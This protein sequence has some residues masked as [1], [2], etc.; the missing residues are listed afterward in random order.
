M[1]DLVVKIK[2]RKD[3]QTQKNSTNF[4]EERAEQPEEKGE[5]R[6]G[7]KEEE[8]R[9]E[10]KRR[11]WETAQKLNFELVTS[12][13]RSHPQEMRGGGKATEVMIRG[14]ILRRFA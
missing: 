11:R 3:K 1:N 9:E 13:I 4:F 12:D 7:R 14:Q 2:L 6:G 10:R 5:E 8:M